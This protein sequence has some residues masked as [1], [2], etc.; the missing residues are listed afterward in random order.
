MHATD[1]AGD[2]LRL[3]EHYRQ[4]KDP[5]LLVLMRQSDGLTDMARQALETEVHHRRL[6]PESEEPDPPP[7]PSDWADPSAPPSEAAP[8]YKEERELVELCTVWS[9]R[10]ALQV[11]RLLDVAGIPFFMGPERATGVA[12]VT[13]NF[14]NGVAVRIMRIGMPWTVGPMQ[15]Y[16]PKDEP[17]EETP[18]VAD[19]LPIHCPRCQSTDVV[20]N[21]LITEPPPNDPTEFPPADASS[22]SPLSEAGSGDPTSRP[23]AKFDWTCDSCGN[24]WQDDGVAKED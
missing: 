3:A 11:Q 9:Q 1:A 7:E 23:P 4:M 18:E 22:R 15:S 16:F 5:E 14:A 19:E 6:Q 12:E 2:H 20:F 21:H 24:K 10:D 13:S 17:P 8:S